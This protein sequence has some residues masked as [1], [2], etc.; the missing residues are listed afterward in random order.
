[1]HNTTVTRGA[2]LPWI[3]YGHDLG[4]AWG[5]GGVLD[6]AARI[7]GDLAALEDAG[8]EVVRWFFFCDGRALDGETGLTDDAA[9]DARAIFDLV[10]EAELQIMPVLFDYLLCKRAHVHD[11]VQMFGRRE[12]I[13]NP[14]RLVDKLVRPLVELVGDHPALF[15]WD[16]INEP[17]WAMPAR[18]LVE[19]PVSDAQMQRFVRA[20]S[21]VVG[22]PCTVG[23]ASL[24]DLRAHWSW[25]TLQTF[26]HYVA[27]SGDA[28]GALCTERSSTRPLEIPPGAS[29]GWP[30][31]LNGEDKESDRHKVLT[32][33]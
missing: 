27:T 9:D 18:A 15:A 21:E 12:Q 30:W 16:L 13:V 31:S 1:M 3:N 23:S 17:E 29:G 25:L 33:V 2:N 24:A 8:A 14:A 6:N 10:D 28:A 11:G 20:L 7:K 19:E 4:R 5:Q 26:H 32:L 22:E